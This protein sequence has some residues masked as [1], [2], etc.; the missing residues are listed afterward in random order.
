M[1]QASTIQFGKTDLDTFTMKTSHYSSRVTVWDTPDT[2]VPTDLDLFGR[3]NQV[4]VYGTTGA[5]NVN[6]QGGQDTVVVYPAGLGLEDRGEKRNT[7]HGT[8]NVTNPKGST[9]LTV[10][11]YN[12]RADHPNVILDS[13]RLSGLAGADITWQPTSGPTGGVTT[14]TVRGGTGT[15]GYTV[16][17]T[18]VLAGGPTQLLP[19]NGA[20][21]DVVNIEHTTGALT[22]GLGGGG[23]DVHISPT[24]QDLQSIRGTVTVNSPAT[25]HTGTDRLILHDA[26]VTA[27]QGAVR[28]TI[29]DTSVVRI[30]PGRRIFGPSTATVDYTGIDYLEIDGGA[31]GN[32]FDVQST[33]AKTPVWIHAGANKDSVTVG[34]AT[35]NL[36]AIFGAVHVIGAGTTSLVVDDRALSYDRDAN[37]SYTITDATIDRHVDATYRDR[38]RVTTLH[39]D[40]RISYSGLSGITLYAGSK[41]ANTINAQD[42][43]AGTPV[44]VTAGTLGDTINVGSPR[45]PSPADPAASSLANIQGLL[46]VHGAGSASLN[47]NDGSTATGQDYTLWADHIDWA[48]QGTSP[49]PTH[50][51]YDGV[52]KLVINGST[53]SDTYNV[54]SAQ[55]GTPV[56][57]SA[58]AGATINVS[59]TAHNLDNVQGSLTFHGPASG[60]ATLNVDDQ[61]TTS[62]TTWTRTPGSITRSRFDGAKLFRT[63]ITYDHIPNVVINSGH[64]AN[65]LQGHDPAAPAWA[66][67]ALPLGSTGD[68]EVFGVAT[69]AA[70]NFYVTGYFAGTVDFGPGPGVTKLTALGKSDAFVAKYTAAGTL[71]WVRSFGGPGSSNST[72]GDDLKVD[73]AG[74]AYVAMD[75]TGPINIAGTT[76]TGAG[77]SDSVMV[78]VDSSGTVRWA[79]QAGRSAAASSEGINGIAIDTAGDVY[80]TG[81]FHGTATFA[82]RSLTSAAGSSSND[83]FFIK[84]DQNGTADWVQQ[85]GGSK[86]DNEGYGMAADAAGN[87]YATGWFQGTATIA[88]QTLTGAGNITGFLVQL[89]AGTGAVRWTRTQDSGKGDDLLYRVAVDAAGNVYT[90]GTFENTLTLGTTRLTSA[91]DHDG[92]V[93]EYTSGGTVPWATRMGGTGN[94]G[95][96]NITV[97]AAGNVYASGWFQGTATFG[98][99]SLTSANGYREFVARLNPATGAVQWAVGTMDMDANAYGSSYD[100]AVDGAG[101]LY[102]AGSFDGT[103]NADAGPGTFNLT[104]A[105]GYDGW[106]IQLTQQA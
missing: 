11:A 23:N 106:V 16:A 83:A 88:G 60:S 40:A 4:D 12:D 104:S 96:S 105:G 82:G 94:D 73:A 18:D 17:Q 75:F 48:P 89:A 53:G 68:D 80:A 28:Y 24:A 30:Q 36:N 41:A 61:A 5:L 38:E 62:S 22:V 71:L 84:L 95:A 79:R 56:T 31:T 49:A 91:G 65:T 86:G 92:F 103:A 52:A 93:A 59:P 44:T 67:L 54:E 10:N 76:F 45:D 97:D 99:T 87:V 90:A 98:G 27:P 78:K 69:D 50:I 42:V 13:G 43:L 46:T 3:T 85:L 64:G 19:G 58:A 15:N 26:K 72:S 77:T 14:L 6:G 47:V 29:T 66:S 7:I 34:D 100:L 81:W 74:N 101:H 55:A 2:P 20:G 70:G 9:T 63:Q 33:E 57:I 51:K 1:A 21:T 25:G 39:L 8:V 37:S 32:T 102:V 35:N